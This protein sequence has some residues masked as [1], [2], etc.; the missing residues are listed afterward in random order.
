MDELVMRRLEKV[1]SLAD[2]L[3]VSY[4]KGFGGVHEV[5]TMERLAER[6]VPEAV[7]YID[8]LLQELEEGVSCRVQH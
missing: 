7:V 1:W 4:G 6:P 2:L 8:G 5:L 3:K